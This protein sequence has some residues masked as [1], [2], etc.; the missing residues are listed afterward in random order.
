M[1]GYFEE[2]TMTPGERERFRAY[3][4]FLL[5]ASGLYLWATSRKG[6]TPVVV[7]PLIKPVELTP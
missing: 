1:V 2:D 5:G 4:T 3:G 7:L 6:K